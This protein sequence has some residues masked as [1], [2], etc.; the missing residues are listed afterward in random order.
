MEAIFYTLSA[1]LA[2]GTI[3][4]FRDYKDKVVLVVNTASRCGFT[5]QYKDLQEIY[6]RYKE[7][8]LEILAFPCNQFAG[9]E[10]GNANEIANF[11]E[12]NYGISFPLF[13]KINVNG[14]DTHPVYAYLKKAAPGLGGSEAIKW[15]FTKFLIDREGN[16]IHR[17]APIT[18]PKALIGELE[19]LLE[20]E[21]VS[22]E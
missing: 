22:A 11:C 4:N 5:P 7:R 16:V 17:F 18:S 12:V 10:P 13:A 20:V 21:K 2:D 9:Q 14:A 8:G 19:R 15:N 3:K 6:S 1:V